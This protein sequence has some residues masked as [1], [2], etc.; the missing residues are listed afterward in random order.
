MSVG[1]VQLGLLGV[2]QQLWSADSSADCG[3]F[4]ADDT[5]SP[6]PEAQV[7]INICET[8]LFAD[9]KRT[10]FRNDLPVRER[11]ASFGLRKTSEACIW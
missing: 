4:E 10:R 8:A 1:N 6:T 7:S 9:V 5:S 3:D 11:L 2:V